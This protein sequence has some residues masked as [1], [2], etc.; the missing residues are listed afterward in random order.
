MLKCFLVGLVLSVAPACAQSTD[1]T[2]VPFS[3]PSRPRTVKVDV[4]NGAIAVSGYDG[5]EVLI[6]SRSIHA[7]HEDRRTQGLHRIET[8]PGMTVEEQDNVVTIKS[9]GPDSGRVSIQVPVATSLQLKTLNGGSITV[10]RIDGEIDADDLNGSI[11]LTN[12]SGAVVAHSQ[13]GSVTAV[14]NRVLPNKA[15]SFTSMNGNIDV[16]LPD[17]VKAR[18][19]MSTDNGDIYTDFDVKLD[20]NAR[21]V[22]QEGRE[23]RGKYRVQVDR[24]V[25]GTI[26][27]GGA[28]MRF[29]TVNGRV[30]I[31]KKK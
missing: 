11:R 2:R 13:N 19:R 5:K 23:G 29:S 3:D 18:V 30:Y 10:D 17:D 14:L 28:D 6:D 25:V 8:N 24:A 16:T 12:V 15:M 22:I 31:R 26:N 9:N 1:Q 20:A 4:L 27:G 7:R 21:P